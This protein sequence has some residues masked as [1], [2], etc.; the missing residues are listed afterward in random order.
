M[1]ARIYLRQTHTLCLA[2]AECSLAQAQVCQPKAESR[3][4]SRAVFV[5]LSP[6]VGYAAISFSAH[7]P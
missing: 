7:G 2:L 5:T 1:R 3:A 6:L 4:R